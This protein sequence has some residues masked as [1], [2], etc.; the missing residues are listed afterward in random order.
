MADTRNAMLQGQFAKLQTKPLS[1]EFQN[2]AN[3][4]PVQTFTAN[5]YS[6]G[7]VQ[8]GMDTDG[9]SNYDTSSPA[10]NVDQMG[11]APQRPQAP[12]PMPPM[13]GVTGGVGMTPGIGMGGPM[14]GAMRQTYP[15]M[16]GMG[17]RRGY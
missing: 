6:S 7:V 8:P 13:G 2:A 11:Q 9:V 12:V 17:Q 3:K 1:Q 5:Q 15:G 10:P 14:R 4:Q 16:F